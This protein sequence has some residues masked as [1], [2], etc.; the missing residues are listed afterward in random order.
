MIVRFCDQWRDIASGKFI[1]TFWENVFGSTFSYA[2]GEV[3]MTKLL[4]D[5]PELELSDVR[6]A[7]RET[8]TVPEGT[9][10]PLGFDKGLYKRNRI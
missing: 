1:L 7:W 6:K 2:F 8:G 4:S 10:C 5:N 3:D 9:H